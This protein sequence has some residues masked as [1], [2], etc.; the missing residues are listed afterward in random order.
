MPRRDFFTFCTS[1][2]PLELKAIGLLSEVR[3]CPAAETI[4]R[5]GEPA[6]ALY[7]INRGVVEMLEENAKHDTKSTYLSRGDI[8]GDAGTLTGHPRQHVARTCEPASLQCFRQSD[9]PELVRRVP[10]FFLYLAEG[11]AA[12]LIEQHVGVVAPSLCLELSGNL[13]NFDLVTV[14]QTIV[15]SGQTGELAINDEGGELISA[16]FFENGQPRSGQ[17]QHLTGEDAFWQLFQA[18]DLRGTFSFASGQSKISYLVQA[19]NIT[20]SAEDMLIN[21][22]QKR[23]EFHEVSREIPETTILVR[24]EPSQRNLNLAPL[25]DGEV[26]EQ[27]WRN[28]FSRP[29]SILELYGNL[30]VSELKIYQAVRELVRSGHL[31][32]S[33]D[34]P[35]EK[36]A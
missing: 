5:P 35:V 22:L 32:L 18:D 15:N 27:I 36:I 16:F 2:Q 28:L 26:V 23:D 25:P 29:R 4:Y 19:G 21:A 11:L 8:F 12:R 3:H 20:R 9:F 10:A 31:T 34:P 14:Y 13:A 6:D 30:S 1:L 17:F 33:C 7:I 24:G